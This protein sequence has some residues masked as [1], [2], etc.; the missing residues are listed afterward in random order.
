MS[1]GV[2]QSD[3]KATGDATYHH[4][5]LQHHKGTPNCDIRLTLVDIGVALSVDQHLLDDL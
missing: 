5:K 2:Q 3:V 1:C 4:E